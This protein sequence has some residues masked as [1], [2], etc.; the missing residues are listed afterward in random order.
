MSVG[1]VAQYQYD[2]QIGGDFNSHRTELSDIY[3]A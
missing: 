2:H 3:D 1:V